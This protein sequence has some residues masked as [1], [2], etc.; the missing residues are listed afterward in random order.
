MNI[1]RNAM[2]SLHMSWSLAIWW[3]LRNFRKPVAIGG[4]VFAML[5]VIA[6]LGTGEHY[7][8]DLVVSFPFSLCLQAI[9]SRHLPFARRWKPMAVGALLTIVWLLLLRYELPIFWISPVIPWAAIVFTVGVSLYLVWP[10][11]SF[12][13]LNEIEPVPQV[14]QAAVV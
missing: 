14:A 13:A 7:L 11:T 10:L 8:I 2:P 4:F 1:A 9:V 12:E 6:T 5:T 3:N